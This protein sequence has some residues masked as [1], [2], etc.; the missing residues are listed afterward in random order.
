MHS[1]HNISKSALAQKMLVFIEVTELDFLSVT[2]NN[3]KAQTLDI[4]TR[5]LFV[6]LF[7]KYFRLFRLLLVTLITFCV[8]L[9]RELFSFY[10]ER[11]PP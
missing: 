2:P 8:R 10:I 11:R 9:I 6:K 4:F 7:F 1:T 3:Q 5:E